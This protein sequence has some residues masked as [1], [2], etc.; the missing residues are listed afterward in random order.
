MVLARFCRV[1]RPL[2]VVAVLVAVAIWSNPGQSAE[3]FRFYVRQQQRPVGVLHRLQ[4]LA[5]LL[6]VSVW[7]G[8]VASLGF[9]GDRTFLGAFD[10]WIE[11]PNVRKM[12]KSGDIVW[13]QGR[14]PEAVFVVFLLVY[15][16][17][18]LWPWPMGQHFIASSQNVRSGRLW[19]LLT[20]QISHQ[21]V[22]HLMSNVFFMFAT[23]PRAQAFLGRAELAG[24]YFLG[25]SLG[26]AL[27]LVLS[28]LLLRGAS[29]VECFG[30]S[31]ALFACLAYLLAQ[32]SESRFR[33]AGY[34]FGEVSFLLLQLLVD[35]CARA[36]GLRFLPTWKCDVIAHLGGF[37]A[38]WGYATWRRS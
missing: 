6:E 32:P 4:E 35:A 13:S 27:S 11:V 12:W 10:S 16:A 20:A 29:F 33:W 38:G 23:L 21:E 36:G 24:L 15:L 8:G 22:L 34:E 17:W 1:F 3:S 9:E 25:G 14:D 37:A 2:L 7:N 5:G 26:T 19:C 28:S 31:S 18:Q 30:A